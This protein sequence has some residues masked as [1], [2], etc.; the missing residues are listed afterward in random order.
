MS[1]SACTS[2]VSRREGSPEGRE[3]RR[4]ARD[5]R[6][7]GS[8]ISSHET[9][10]SIVSLRGTSEARSCDGLPGVRDA[11]PGAREGRAEG[12]GF[13]RDVAAGE[14]GFFEEAI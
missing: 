11:R 7:S 3:D 5:G 12:G 8:S 2:M 13:E 14:G 10:T 9:S 1:H 6:C 4:G